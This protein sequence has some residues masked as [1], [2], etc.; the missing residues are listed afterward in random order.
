MIN[1]NDNVT[2]RS[3]LDLLQKKSTY[4]NSP[5]IN[6]KNK[7]K[8]DTDLLDAVSNISKS[9]NND[10]N[11]NNDDNQDNDYS[12]RKSLTKNNQIKYN[13][14]STSKINNEKELG[15]R[16]S[17]ETYSNKDDEE[18]GSS[19][20]IERKCSMRNFQLILEIVYTL[21]FF[22][23]AI[24]D[25]II[26]YNMITKY[27][28]II[29]S[30]FYYVTENSFRDVYY[31]FN[32]FHPE[33]NE[34]VQAEYNEEYDGV[35][36]TYPLQLVSEISPVCISQIEEGNG[37]RKLYFDY[38]TGYKSEYN[39]DKP[40]TQK[41]C[42][43]DSLTFNTQYKI[44]K[45]NNIAICSVFYTEKDV[46]VY[47][48]KNDCNS[49]TLDLE[50][51]RNNVDYTTGK[52]NCGSITDYNVCVYYSIKKVDTLTG[53][54]KYI[55]TCP[56]FNILLFNQTITNSTDPTVISEKTNEF[57]AANN[58]NYSGNY[59]TDD[60]VFF[61][62]DDLDISGSNRDS[63][64]IFLRKVSD[65]YN[66]FS[67][68]LRTTYSHYKYP[69]NNE[70][71]SNKYTNYFKESIL[72]L[73]L[74]P[75]DNFK[76]YNISLDNDYILLNKTINTAIENQS[77]NY[78]VYPYDYPLSKATF[79]YTEIKFPNNICLDILSK[80]S[81]YIA[82]FS[83]LYIYF[84][85]K[86]CYCLFVWTIF[87]IIFQVLI[88]IYLRLYLIF[89]E[90]NGKLKI[91]DKIVEGTTKLSIFSFSII[92]YI[93]RIILINFQSGKITEKREFLETLVTNNCL[94][95]SDII[96]LSY[97][98]YYTYLGDLEDINSLAMLVIIVKFGL[99]GGCYVI[100]YVLNKISYKDNL[101]KDKKD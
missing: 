79:Y 86:S 76:Y 60:I 27:N 29:E 93:V 45:W 90:L 66:G 62:I 88:R 64:F 7:E 55:Q 6:I 26:C 34:C 22:A 48:T 81:D 42:V 2:N 38:N 35:I 25:C 73:D 87:E 3:N 78:K 43:S 50:D 33:E 10:E 63:I 75:I 8:S 52:L 95:Y 69:S 47:L 13:I 28:T 71:Y 14:T 83:Q 74:A 84:Y 4:N 99:L 54:N 51:K 98:E 57:I 65:T 19:K 21:L 37:K 77:T 61:S 80:C 30:F 20:K 68:K 32:I 23:L 5:S 1:R 82:C 59:L 46:K 53:T 49:I 100:E 17:K 44:F 9:F 18:I 24:Y 97:K 91:M 15:K 58:L 89:E 12:P 92:I 36:Q 56:F 85:E 67:F 101:T 16:P 11:N 94:N 39:K 41:P 72:N 31:H 70:S 96:N 40:S